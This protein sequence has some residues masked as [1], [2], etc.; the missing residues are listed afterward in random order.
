M[1]LAI[2]ISEE[3]P[4][5]VACDALVVGARSGD[6]F[7][8][9]GPGPAIDEAMEGHLRSYL[10]S[11]G[12]EGKPGEVVVLP[13]FGRIE[14][15]TVAVT[16]LGAPDDQGASAVRRAS[17]AAAR[18]LSRRSV[19]ASAVHSDRDGEGGGGAAAASAEG[20]VLG[21]YRFTAYKSEAG[22]RKLERVLLLGAPS[23]AIDRGVA[24]ASATT[25]ARD[26]VN[27]PG[28][29]LTPDALAAKAREV[30]AETGL[31]CTV[32]DE[33][34]MAK[35]SFGGVLGVGR[36]ASN[37]PR[38]IQLHHKPEGA[39]GKLAL[40]GKGVTF[41]TGGLSLKDAK[42]MEEMKTD[43]SGAAAVLG[44]MSMLHH[45]DA[46]VEVTAYIPAT[47]NMPGPAA[48]KPGDVITHYGG[49]TSEVLNT[50]AEG[51]LILADALALASEEEPD[52]IVDLATL[53]GSIMIALGR[54]CSG[55]FANDDAL[56]SELIA[57]GETA[58]ERY[59]RMPL[60]DDYKKELESEI[61]DLKNIGTRYGGSI[62]AALFLDRFVSKG[63][64][65]AHLDIAGTART[66]ATT[67]E[68]PR[69]ATGF[70][71]RTLLAWI[72]SRSRANG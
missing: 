15:E 28:S 61:A 62:F 32:W 43:M 7:E 57:A 37:P 26:L 60:L 58:G 5:A 20:Y 34:E 13:S 48:I 11:E 10:E 12:F 54:T 30:A 21:S 53:T 35:R 25:L 8:L 40:V 69:G 38:M 63:H 4:A 24:Y 71:A 45:L 33:A 72:E 55:L 29:E 36:G 59:W 14:A 22:A 65:W 52:A 6:P 67:D 64:A 50:D 47:E 44:A 39:V 51:R 42:Q 31:V 9:V 41:D 27:E 3:S 16:G 1:P 18:H 56:A 66:E 46:A 49:T 17:A 19:V 23:D 2:E 70:G 68:T